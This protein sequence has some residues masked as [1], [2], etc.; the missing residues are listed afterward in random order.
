MAHDAILCFIGFSLPCFKCSAMT[1]MWKPKGA[2]STH[3]VLVLII[4]NVITK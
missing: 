4:R 3:Q 2:R 1:C